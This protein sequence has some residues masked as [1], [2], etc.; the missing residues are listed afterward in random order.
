MLD[1]KIFHNYICAGCLN[2]VRHSLSVKT[3]MPRPRRTIRLDSSTCWPHA[4]AM[5]GVGFAERGKKGRS[6]TP[7]VV[8]SAQGY[9]PHIALVAQA[10][11]VSR[12]SAVCRSHDAVELRVVKDGQKQPLQGWT[13]EMTL[14][15]LIF[16]KQNILPMSD[17]LFHIGNLMNSTAK[18][19]RSD[20]GLRHLH[21]WRGADALWGLVLDGSE[22]AQI[23]TC[24]KM[25]V[26]RGR[27]PNNWIP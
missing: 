4:K 7:N 23:L 20:Q 2:D 14:I 13:K 19:R 21:R 18:D 9:K 25:R 16:L 24:C 27:C 11:M 22:A 26:T 6:F 3:Q 5:M 10:Q 1:L 12:P 17:L 8:L 15:R